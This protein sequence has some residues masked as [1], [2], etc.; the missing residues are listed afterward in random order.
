MPS[1]SVFWWNFEH[2]LSSLWNFK[3]TDAKGK[4]VWDH[5]V[6]WKYSKLYTILKRKITAG[7]FFVWQISFSESIR[8]QKKKTTS[9]KSMLFK[10]SNSFMKTK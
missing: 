2:R 4:A 7:T 6:A 10:I 8:S 3:D 5:C 9:E 1:F